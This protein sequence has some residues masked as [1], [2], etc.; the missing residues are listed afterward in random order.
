MWQQALAQTYERTDGTVPWVI[1]LG[2]QD[3]WG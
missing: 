2:L 3:V 1:S